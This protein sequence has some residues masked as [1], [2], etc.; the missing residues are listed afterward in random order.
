MS[1]TIDEDEH[2]NTR[3]KNAKLGCRWCHSSNIHSIA[4]GAK[5]RW[6]VEVPT[7]VEISRLLKCEDCGL[8]CFSASFSDKELDTM[9]SGYRN[10]DYQRRRAKYEPW[11]TKKINDSIGH[12]SGVLNL[13]RLHLVNLLSAAFKNSSRLIDSPTRVLDVGGDEGQFIP[14]IDSII[15]R[16]VLEVSGIRPVDGA[17]F[18]TSWNEVDKFSPD[19]IMM[20]H[21]LEHI[22]NA[23]EN[24]EKASSILKSGG[25]LY[26][27]IPLDR[28]VKVSKLF[29]TRG[30]MRYTQ[31]LC[32]IPPLFVVADLLSLVSRKFIGRPVLG[33]VL[34]QNEHINFFDGA[35]ITRVVETLGFELIQESTYK[36]TS[37]VPVLD[38]SAS[39][40][41]FVR[42]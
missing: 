41:L 20:C 17:H 3:I 30:Y 22:E 40:T 39:G 12:S 1:V 16:A 18:F 15:E 26:I 5:A 37:G 34:K 11:Y 2:K 38:M 19:M 9:Y 23:R 32:K 27:E 8:V 10:S 31:F 6:I 42:R 33:A 25:L 13:R 21:V 36:P 4:V 35:T 29:S 28:P 7:S 24:I 14:K